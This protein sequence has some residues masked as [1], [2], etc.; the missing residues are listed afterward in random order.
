MYRI[1]TTIKET[2]ENKLYTVPHSYEVTEIR[3]LPEDNSPEME[4]TAS[5]YQGWLTHG[6]ANLLKDVEKSYDPGVK[7]LDSHKS[8]NS[9]TMEGAVMRRSEKPPSPILLT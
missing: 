9:T 8:P 5:S 7:L 3:L 1:K 6:T 2:R 4:P